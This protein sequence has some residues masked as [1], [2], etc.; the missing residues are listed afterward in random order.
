MFCNLKYIS[1]TKKNSMSLDI[2][3]EKW[4]SLAVSMMLVGVMVSTPVIPKNYLFS[5]K[6]TVGKVDGL[7]TF[8]TLGYCLDLSNKTICSTPK[9]GYVFG[10]FL[11]TQP[12]S[13]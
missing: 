11:S 3:I 4:L 5:C 2:F 1:V 6:V 8:G 10:Q 9:I 12:I 13:F 7:L